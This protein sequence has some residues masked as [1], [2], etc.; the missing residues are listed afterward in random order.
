MTAK[1]MAARQGMR[2][3]LAFILSLCVLL[4]VWV[5]YPNLIRKR[6]FI[7]EATPLNNLRTLLI[8]VA[9]YKESYK[10]FPP[11]LVALGPP[12][13][14]RRASAE[15][16]DLVDFRLSSGTKDGYAYR[17]VATDSLHS[18]KFDS[19]TISADPVGTG[20]TKR[21]HYFTDQ[22][23]VIRVESEHA[24]TPTSPPVD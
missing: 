17:Y 22:T 6:A 14:D 15:T 16:A 1:K 5:A 3:Y 9:M 11:S 23:A 10:D 12:T 21:P 24:A 2:F 18:G 7:T 4:A 20:A 13:K 19:F 8:A